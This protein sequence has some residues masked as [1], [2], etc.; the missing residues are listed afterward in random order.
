MLERIARAKLV[1]P[2]LLSLLGLMVLI[3]LGTWQLQRR[4]WKDTIIATLKARSGAPAITATASWPGLPCHDLKDTGLANPCEY[5]PVIV[6]GT[7]DHA[8]ERHIFTAAPNAPGIGPGRGFWVFTPMKLE[9]AGKTVF[10]NR[11][12]V[13]EALKEAG[14][15]VV[16]QTTQAV[17]ITGLYRSVQTR[18]WFDGEND[19]AR[20]IWYV[21]APSEMWPVDPAGG[22]LDE[23]W[24]YVDA[25]G[26]VPA[27]EWPLPLGGR[28]ELAN[29]HLEYAITWFGL[30]ATLAGIFGAFAWGRIKG[31]Q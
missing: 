25:T 16:G 21:R 14:K 22:V 9:G 23:M 20:N 17:E 7:F 29:R 1:V 13:P 24:A 26:P 4:A 8:R 27:G 12:F 6:R 11:G 10:V 30:A 19:A 15:R 5:Q 28:V 2:A 3:G 31:G 18:G